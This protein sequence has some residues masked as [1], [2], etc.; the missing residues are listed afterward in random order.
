[1]P[2][3]GHHHGELIAA[4]PDQRPGVAVQRKTTREQP[5]RFVFCSVK[6]DVFDSKA[7]QATRERI[8]RPERT[9]PPPV[10]TDRGELH[11]RSS[12]RSRRLTSIATLFLRMIW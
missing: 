8:W 5:R 6:T 2:G 3:A 7:P 11:M 12:G 10:R 9:N 4:D 1:V